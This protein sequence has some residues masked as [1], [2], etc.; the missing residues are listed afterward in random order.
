MIELEETIREAEE[1]EVNHSQMNRSPER[2]E[3]A[4]KAVSDIKRRD[5]TPLVSGDHHSKSFNFGSAGRAK[6][7]SEKPFQ[8]HKTGEI[9]IISNEKKDLTQNKQNDNFDINQ[10]TFGINP[11]HENKQNQ[12]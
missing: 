8:S 1:L 12:P 11:H 6:R 9:N 10:A 3:Y 7:P 2:C 4:P 5:I